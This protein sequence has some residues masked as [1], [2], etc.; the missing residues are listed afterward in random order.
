MSK[1]HISVLNIVMPMPH[2]PERY[3]SLFRK[4]FQLK[5]QIVIRGE[6]RG[7]IGTLEQTSLDNEIILT[8]YIYKYID[9]DI[10]DKWLNVI[11]Q[12][13]AQKDEIKQISIPEYLKPHCKEFFYVFTPEKHRLLFLTKEKGKQFSQKNMQKLFTNLFS[14]SSL[15]KEFGT[16]DVTVAPTLDLLEKIFKLQC[17]KNILIE[18]IPPN[19]DDNS[20]DERQMMEELQK[21]NATKYITSIKSDNSKGL[22]LNDR[23][24]RLSQI[25]Q[26]NGKVEA[27]GINQEGQVVTLSTEDHPFIEI[28]DLNPN[29]QSLKDAFLSVA[30][31]IIDKVTNGEGY[32]QDSN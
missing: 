12:Q 5:K 20:E 24:K 21:Q 4:A 32:E 11:A 27:K 22:M 19:A 3:I 17:L 13:V 18:I 25:A 28:V 7:L 15:I 30:R 23:N 10:N 9:I 8:G 1:I 14:D 2:S 6:S 29:I 16:I 26:S 31:K